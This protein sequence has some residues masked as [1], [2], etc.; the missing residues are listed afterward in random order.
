MELN[1][2]TGAEVE[3]ESCYGIVT[4]AISEAFRFHY[5]VDPVFCLI[6]LV[7][8]DELLKKVK[9]LRVAVAHTRV[10]LSIRYVSSKPRESK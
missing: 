7:A 5:A 8:V 6:D 3:K 10:R 9:V 2:Q 4:G 1:Y